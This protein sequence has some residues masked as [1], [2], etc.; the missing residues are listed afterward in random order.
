MN[1]WFRSHCLFLF[2]AVIIYVGRMLE[3]THVA[4]APIHAQSFLTCTAQDAE[5]VAA[6]ILGDWVKTTIHGSLRTKQGDGSG[7]NPS[8]TSDFIQLA[9]C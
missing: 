6:G 7:Q 2:S 8:T 3:M 4:S 5:I 9:Y 1:L